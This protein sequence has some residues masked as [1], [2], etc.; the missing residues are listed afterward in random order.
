MFALAAG[1]ILWAAL[2]PVAA[3]ETA[4]KSGFSFRLDPLVI[5]AINKDLDTNSARFEEY[6][7]LD[8]GFRAALRLLGESAD[9]EK[10]LDLRIV[11]AGRT[12]GRYT[13]NYGV[14]GRYGLV[15][16][17]NKIPHRFGNNGHMLYTQT[18]PGRFEIDDSIQQ[19]LQATLIANRPLV[20]FNFLD[21][22]L[23]PHLAVAQG[24]DIGLERDRTLARFD[25]GKLGPWNLGL[26]YTHESRDGSRPYGSSFGFNNVTELPEPIQYDTTDAE[27]SGEWSGKMGGLRLG[28]RTSKFENDVST[29]IW[30]NPFRFIDSTDASAYSSPGTGS[31]N[32]SAL[33]IADLAPDNKANQL[34]LTGRT[35]IGGSWW[36]NGSAS[37]FQMKQNDPLLPYTLNS[38]IRGINFNGSTFDPTNP[39]NLPERKADREAV[40]TNINATL[41]GQLGEKLDLT[42]RYRYYDYDD[43][44]SRIEFPGYVRYHAVWEAIERITVP[45]NYSV[46][47]AG[48]ELGWDLARKTRLALSYNR[49]SWDRKLREIET[50]DEDIIKLALDNRPSDRWTLRGSYEIGDRSIGPYNTNA[51]EDSFLEEGGVSTNLPGLRKYDEAARQYDSY[52]FLA[53]WLATD[54][55]NLSFGVNGR[56][57]DY[58]K[59]VFGLQSD[60]VM[61]YNADFSYT[62][63]DKVS[64]FLFGQR[65]DRTSKQIARQ[66]GAT[67]SI[68]PLDT[69]F[70]T[71]DEVNDLWGLG[72]NAKLAERWTTELS[73]QWTKSDGN[74]DFTAFAGGAPLASPRR[75]EAQDI[76]NYEDIK[77]LTI[78]CRLDYHVNPHATAGL[79]YRYEDFTIDSFILQGLTNYLPG[80]LLL[81]ANNGDYTANVL[82]VNMSVSF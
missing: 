34:F 6:R 11:N 38:S 30:D 37:R 80:A 12:D 39:A 76:P 82:G 52:K 70:L 7:D 19:A 42:F 51:S 68:N 44:A 5:E 24:V 81:N 1:A 61:T 72:V 48:A 35:K 20:N 55:W 47:D 13:L 21:N 63:S 45:V 73:G 22:L 15:L 32:G 36:L 78:L 16:D 17:Y 4:A 8:S 59:S 10:N 29:L 56:K 54:A 69:W 14:P 53:Q 18:S 75:T 62:P 26:E 66:S 40:T 79:W 28:Y 50:S 67:P 3:Q 71:L 46:A 64:F 74:A 27:I 43:K 49:Q 60:D 57:D 65:A 9:G 41:G 33:G 25:L 31:V 58:D 2:S 77:L 23:A